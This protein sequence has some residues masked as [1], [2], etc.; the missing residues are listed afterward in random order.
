MDILATA[1]LEI[2]INLRDKSDVLSESYL[3]SRI[4]PRRLFCMFD[5]LLTAVPSLLPNFRHATG[6]RKLRDKII[7]L[8]NNEADGLD[9][10]IA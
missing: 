2:P 4:I 8:L 1:L 9:N 10:W 3:S 7:S 5:A 6:F